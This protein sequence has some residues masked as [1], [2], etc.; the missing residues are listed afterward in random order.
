MDI[1]GEGFGADPSQLDVLLGN[2][3]CNVKEVSDSL[4]RC[5]TSPVTT[6]HIIDNN[7]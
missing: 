3:P 5:I 4:I 1:A 2:Y 7:A 6:T